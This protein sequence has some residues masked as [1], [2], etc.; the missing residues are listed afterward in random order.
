[1]INKNK[2]D[3]GTILLRHSDQKYW[4]GTTKLL[5]RVVASLR[6]VQSALRRRD[7]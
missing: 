2:S 7:K 3:I 6:E 1:M 5:H 4:S